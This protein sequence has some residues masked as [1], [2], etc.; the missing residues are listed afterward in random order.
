MSNNTFADSHDITN[1]KGKF[2]PAAQNDN[3]YIL[4]KQLTPSQRGNEAFK[5]LFNLRPIK[6]HYIFIQYFWQ[7]FRFSEKAKITLIILSSGPLG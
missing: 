7:N 4:D 1:Q 6:S 5:K 3:Y 2:L